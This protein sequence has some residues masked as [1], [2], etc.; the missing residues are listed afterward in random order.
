MAR[1]FR[2]RRSFYNAGGHSDPGDEKEWAPRIDKN[3][4]YRTMDIFNGVFKKNV[5]LSAGKS[6]C[7]DMHTIFINFGELKPSK[8]HSVVKPGKDSE[9]TVYLLECGHE[10][11]GWNI[12]K[13]N[14]NR[15]KVLGQDWGMCGVCGADQIYRG[16]EHEW[17]HIIFKSDLAARKI[18]VEQYADQLLKQ[19]PHVPRDELVSFLH[20]LV[21]AFDDIRVNSLWEKVYP[22]SAY[23]IWDRWRWFTLRMGDDVNKSFLAFVFAVAFQLP[24]DP[25]GEFAAMRPIVEWATQKVKYRGFAN[26]LV[27]IKVVLDRCMGTLLA[28]VPPPPQPQPGMQPPPAPPAQQPNQPSNAGAGGQQGSTQNQQQQ[29]QSDGQDQNQQAQGQDSQT[30][31]QGQ[32]SQSQGAGDPQEDQRSAQ[33]SSDEEGEESGGGGSQEDEDQDQGSGSQPVPGQPDVSRNPSAKNVPASDSD[34]SD[35]LQR[36]MQNPVVLDPKEEHSDPKDEDLSAAQSSQTTRAM[37]AKALNQDISDLDALDQMMPT[38]EVD[39]DM[40]KQLDQLQNAV[41]VKSESSQLTG[42]AKARITI[43]DVTTDGIPSGEKIELEGD[44]KFAIQRM[45]SAFF[46]TMGRQKQKRSP[47]GT[48]VDVQSL[49]QYLGD[50]QDPNV[51]E[52]EDVNQ[53][54]AYSVLCDMSGSMHG[55]FPQVCRA[56]EMLK[57][58]LHFPFVIGNLWGFRGGERIQGRSDN[59]DGEVWMYR[60]AK[61]VNWYTGKTP[62]RIHPGFNGLVQVPVECGGIT[63]MNSAINVASAH[64]WRKMPAGMAKRLFLLTDGAPMQVKLSGQNLPEFLLRQFVAKE[65]MAA[66]KHGVQ[67]YT[68]VIGQHSIEEDKCLQMFGPRKF[69]RRVGSDR[70]GTVLASLVLSNFSKYIRARG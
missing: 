51:F 48:V 60:Y 39:S 64:L 9:H 5:K 20:L 65:I 15:P 2:S 18:F 14:N 53:G 58:A 35:A 25:N 55:T 52:N 44:E 68:I 26:M 69:W 6:N 41:T 1:G 7:T 16:F 43:I 57:Q 21:N 70:V 22:G 12:D 54:F 29:G 4:F 36:L 66:R 10:W 34:R 19:A 47:Q 11:E 32:Q 61:N 49:I 37:I 59:L 40:Q 67:V 50:H 8:L 27:D 3:P 31:S 24:T 13:K 56:V 17:Q 63:P 46:R 23:A 30:A 42:N 45:R 33:G 38:G 62:F 28:K